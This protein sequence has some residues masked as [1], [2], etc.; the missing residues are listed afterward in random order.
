MKL[1][2]LPFDSE[3]A[4]CFFQLVL[5]AMR[6]LQP[7]LHRI[8]PMRE[9]GE[10]FH[11]QVIAAA[12]LDRILHHCTTINIKGESYR[13]KDRKKHGLTI[14]TKIRHT[15]C[16]EN[17]TVERKLYNGVGNLNRRKWEFYAGNDNRITN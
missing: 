13:L 2:Y 9:W 12:I 14:S 3:G 4:N 17:L 6:R 5:N 8:N 15:F 7:S 1:G 10:I 11:D 16:L